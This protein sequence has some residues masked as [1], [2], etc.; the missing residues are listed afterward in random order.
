MF[1]TPQSIRE[2][3]GQRLQLGFSKLPLDS[4]G[5]SVLA[6]ELAASAVDVRPWSEHHLIS[7][8]RHDRAVMSLGLASAGRDVPSVVYY[9][10]LAAAK[11]VISALTGTLGSSNGLLVGLVVIYGILTI[12]EVRTAASPAES[13]LFWIVYSAP[14]NRLRRTNAKALFEAELSRFSEIE[15]EDF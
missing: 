2:Q 11:L 15:G 14:N 4:I 7:I 6:R 13:L 12:G 10:P 3:I 5:A 8:T 1:D 9:K